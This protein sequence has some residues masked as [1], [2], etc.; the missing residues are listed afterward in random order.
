LD[1]LGIRVQL[2]SWEELG[3]EARRIR[4]EV[5]VDEQ[6]IALDL[7][8]DAEDASSLH[9]VAST[10]AGL[11]VGTAR[12]LADGHIGRVAVTREARGQGVGRILLLKLMAAARE[13]GQR[14]VELFSQVSAQ[15]F[16]QRYGFQVVG[17]PFDDAGIPHV[18]MRARL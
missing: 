7:E 14:E 6:G 16:Y 18:T 8:F 12:L 9:A 13:R 4:I 1:E 11:A 3:G 15:Q 5:F 2:G 10:S 17:P